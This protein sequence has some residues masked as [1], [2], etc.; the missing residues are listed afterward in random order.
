VTDA[1]ELLYQGDKGRPG[2]K[3]LETLL[4]SMQ[5][6]EKLAAKY[7]M[8]VVTGR[9]KSDCDFALQTFGLTHLFKV[10]TRVDVVAVCCSVLQCVA[11][12]CSVLQ[13]VVVVGR[14]KLDHGF[15]LQTFGLAHL[16]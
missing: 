9:P 15:A 4:P 5:L 3:S 2:L 1:F 11:V 16:F 8:A 10:C 7:P 14:P 12:C 6:L 13:C